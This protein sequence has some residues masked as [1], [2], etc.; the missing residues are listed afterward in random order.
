MDKVSF[1][2][3]LKD[4]SSKLHLD[5][6][7]E[8][9]DWKI[10]GVIDGEEYV[11]TISTDTKIISKLLEIQ[12]FPKFKEF[13]DQIG[14]DIVLAEHQNWY[15]DLSFVSKQDTEIKYAVDIKTTYRLKDYDGFCNGFTLGSHGEYFKNRKSTKNIQYPY[16]QYGAH[17]CIG[18]IY[19]RA[20]EL[21]IDETRRF[22]I[23]DISKMRPVIRDFVCFAEEKWKI[24]SDRTGSGNTANIG[25][26]E[27][28]DDLLNANGT[29]INLGE[30]VFD[31]FWVI[32]GKVEVPHPKKG[33]KNTKGKDYPETKKLT[34][35]SEYLQIQGIDL[36]LE[37]K[38]R[39][40]RKKEKKK[41][42]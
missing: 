17:F 8:S 37:N 36:S 30:D 33:Q 22:H 9:G 40:K 10:K 28:I 13:A 7:T 35:L 38:K 18:I 15:P 4:F 42:K 3:E 12:L 31:S 27:Y 23:G 6:M 16:E 1:L 34:L 19:S 2:N 24:A 20:S 29:F 11:Y 32:R 25:S 26:I 21:D 41:K 14:F 39:T 5:L